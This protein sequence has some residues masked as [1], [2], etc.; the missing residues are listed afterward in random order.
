MK[1]RRLLTAL[2]TLAVAAGALTA[3]S[4]DGTPDTQT[5]SGEAGGTSQVSSTESE[6]KS[7]G[8]IPT[9]VWYQI[10]G[11]PENLADGV[12]AMNAY[13]AEK[14][15]V[16]I[17]LKFL[18][19]G[20][21]ADKIKTIVS[22]GE[23]YD[24]MFTNGDWYS[25]HVDMGAFTDITGLLDTQ[26]PA[27]KSFIPEDVWKGV[28]IKGKIY[29]VPTYKD[30]SQRQ[31]W[32]WDKE[33]VDKYNINY[34]SLIT[35]EDL[36]PVLRQIKE[37]EGKSFYPFILDKN[38][39][40]GQFM[41]FDSN[42]RYDDETATV[43]E[44]LER[45]EMVD[46]FKQIHAWYKDGIINPDA[47]TMT[48][49]PK[50]RTCFSAQGFPGANVTWSANMGKEVVSQPWSPAIYTTGTILGSVN[51]ISSNS[52]YVNEALKYL[53]LA[54]TDSTLRNMLAYG[55][56]DVNFKVLEDKTIEK[57]NDTWTAPAYAQATF[58]TMY[59][60]S[61]N[62]PDQ[63]TLVQKQNEEAVPSVLLGFTFDRAP[64][65]AELTALEAVGAK[66]NAELYTGAKDPEV[67]IPQYLA[68]K[69]AAG[70]EKVLAE[71][72]KQINEFLGK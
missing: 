53:E 60:V 34:E 42:V 17:D 1:K 55:I 14:I 10:G 46:F 21:W 72:Q 32:V 23:P 31:Y 64:V 15:G 20:V 25:A 71:Y 12:E 41:Y 65:E 66:Y 61:P 27:L 57:L 68:D 28:T 22:T 50:V 38:G 63:W 54:N 62:P 59:P 13:T 19:W 4:G 7:D 26:A 11:A 52:K 33:M 2:L 69:K 3:C 39:V 6:S 8:E 40:N 58:F 18:D 36:D 37:G 48:E 30:S 16:K 35:L 24:I 47:P 43:Q 70:S 44:V 5:S 29:A 56:E 67:I 45:Q 49:L 9:L 51:A